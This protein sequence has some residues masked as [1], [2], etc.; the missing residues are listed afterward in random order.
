MRRSPDTLLPI[1]VAILDGALRLHQSGSPQ[2]HG[3][4]LAKQLA[5]GE[6]ASRL[7]SHGTLYKALGRLET[8][9]LLT[10]AWEDPGAA[11]DEGRPRRRLYEITGE[12]QLALARHRAGHRGRPPLGVA[13]L[14]PT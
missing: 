2:F 13:G 14:E 4:L 10:S 11:A 1:E 5:A 12:T 9:G 7:T 3:F 6:G 8:A